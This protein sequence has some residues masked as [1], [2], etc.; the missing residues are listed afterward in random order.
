MIDESTYRRNTIFNFLVNS[1]KGTI[2]F[3]SIDASDIRKTTKRI[4]MMMDDVFE[5]VGERMSFKF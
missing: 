5:E 3:M 1:P 4:F 2:F